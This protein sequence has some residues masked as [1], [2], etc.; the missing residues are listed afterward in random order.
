M[1]CFGLV[2]LAFSL[3]LGACVTI[4][5]GPVAPER[6]ASY[7]RIGVL[8]TMG[9][10]F[11]KT[12]V[13]LLVFGNDSGERQCNLGAD[14]MITRKFV[15]VLSG[16][17]EVIDLSRHRNAFMATPRYWPGGRWQGAEGGKPIAEV[18][19]DLMGGEAVDAYVVISPGSG[20]VG[21]TNQ[22]IDG[23]GLVESN[24]P[25][26]KFD[27]RFHFAYDVT[28]IDGADFTVVSDLTAHPVGKRGVGDFLLGKEPPVYAPSMIG[29]PELWD[30]PAGHQRQLRN[31]LSELLD[32]S[33]PDT[34]RRT[35]LID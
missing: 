7:D 26:A 4:P 3:L 15:D 12:V 21:R 34:L 1:R 31:M 9:D 6:V 33:V 2:F 32:K 10:T 13:G 22:Y 30:D 27:I 14:E 17:Y 20:R 24:T 11:A 28:V 16:R 19:R 35:A 5:S 25:L 23:I 18:T 29:W 8:S